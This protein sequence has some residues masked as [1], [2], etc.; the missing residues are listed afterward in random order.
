[1]VHY[2]YVTFVFFFNQQ[3]KFF[4]H[5]NVLLEFLCA[6]FCVH[7]AKT[8]AK[9]GAKENPREHIISPEVIYDA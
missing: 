3:R 4:I 5:I 8:A 7:L 2:I 1:M 6:L 9:A